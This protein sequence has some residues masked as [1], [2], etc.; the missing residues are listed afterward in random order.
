MN[1]WKRSS[2]ALLSDSFDKSDLAKIFGTGSRFNLWNRSLFEPDRWKLCFERWELL[3]D[4]VVRSTRVERN[5][6]FETT[7]FPCT[8]AQSIRHSFQSKRIETSEF[9]FESFLR[10]LMF[11]FPFPVEG[12]NGLICP[13]YFD[14]ARHATFHSYRRTYIRIL[15][16]LRNSTGLITFAR[17]STI[18]VKQTNRQLR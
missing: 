9:S 14:T 11:F 2:S 1:V 10:K 12:R 4:R 17:T 13:R 15:C 7:F 6:V 5:V 8:L 16:N 3:R 18:T